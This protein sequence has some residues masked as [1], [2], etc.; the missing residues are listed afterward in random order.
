LRDRRG[1]G[2]GA[3]PLPFER[4]LPLLPLMREVCHA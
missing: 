3:L 1:F 4:P 2:F